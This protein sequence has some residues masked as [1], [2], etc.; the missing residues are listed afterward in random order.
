MDFALYF[1]GPF[2]MSAIVTFA[3]I[4]PMIPKPHCPDCRKSLWAWT[5]EGVL[6]RYRQHC[7]DECPRW[8]FLK[9]WR[10]GRAAW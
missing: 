9:A 7:R 1:L 5:P 8:R 10:E 6:H 4:Y 2:L 3:L